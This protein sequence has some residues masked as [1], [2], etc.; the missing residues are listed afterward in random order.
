MSQIDTSTAWPLAKAGRTSRPASS[1]NALSGAGWC[2]L[3]DWPKSQRNTC[4]RAGDRG[5][6]HGEGRRGSAVDV[7]RGPGLPPHQPNHTPLS[8]TTADSYE[9]E[10]M[11]KQRP[12]EPAIT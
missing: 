6:R 12:A 7:G 5:H 4:E 9:I 3:A 1:R 11:S 2:S 8:P 10:G